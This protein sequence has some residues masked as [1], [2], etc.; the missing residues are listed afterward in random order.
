MVARRMAP[1]GGTFL[2]PLD[3][4]VVAGVLALLI[5]P[6]VVSTTAA[7]LPLR[8][9]DRAADELVL[10]TE[11]G[12]DLQPVP[13]FRPGSDAAPLASGSGLT[14]GAALRAGVRQRL[15]AVLGAAHAMAV[16][17][18]IENPNVR[19]AEEATRFGNEAQISYP[20]R[21]PVVEDVLGARGELSPARLATLN[22]AAALLIL[23]A[24]YHGDALPN[25][26]PV[27]Y[28][29]L[30]RGRAGGCAPQLN[31]AFLV[32]TDVHPRDDDSAQEFMQ[33]AAACPGDPTPLWL[34]GQFQS[35][36][37]DV[38]AQIDAGGVPLSERRA[39]PFETFRRLQSEL[40]GSHAGWSG[41]AD[42]HLRLAYQS[43]SGAP[44]TARNHFRQ[45]RVLY[46]HA[47]ALTDDP[48]L[49][50][51]LARA[52]AGLGEY[53]A[54]VAEQR[55]AVAGQDHAAHQVRLVEYLERAGRFAA[56][57]D[58]G[59]RFLQAA[60]DLAPRRG[61]YPKG[62]REV[63]PP[64]P[65]EDEDANLPVSWG[66]GVVR[67]VNLVLTPDFGGAGA[68][69]VDLAFIPNFRPERG[70]TGYD[71]WCRAWSH[72]R[73]LVLAGRHAEALA[74]LPDT[75]SA[76]GPTFAGDACRTFDGRAPNLVAIAAYEAGDTPAAVEW[77]RSDPALDLSV[78]EEANPE[79][80]R[81]H[82]LRQ[83]LWRFGGNLERAEA[84]A[85]EWLAAAP[86]SP[87]ALDRRGEIAFLLG[88]YDEAAQYFAQAEP[89]DE[90]A[91]AEAQLKQG[92]ALILASRHDEARP[93]LDAAILAAAPL[94]V[95]SDEVL[96][97]DPAA[98]ARYVRAAFVTY[99]ARA[100]MGDLELRVGSD[101]PAAAAYGAA[102]TLVADVLELFPDALTML[103][104][105]PEVI[106]N[107]LALAHISA[108][109]AGAAL[110]HAE[111]A[112][113]VDP[114]NPLFLQTRAFAHQE[115]GDLEAAAR[116]YQR[117]LEADPTVFSA[118]NDLGAVR[119]VQ[120]RTAEAVAAFRQAVGAE[121][122]YALG[123]FNLGVAL[124]RLGPAEMVRS[125]AALSQAV[126]LDRGLRDREREIVFDSEPYFTTLDLSRPLPPRWTFV[127]SYER[128]P[129]GVAAGV[130]VL[131]VLRL[132]LVLLPEQGSG[133]VVHRVLE[134][135]RRR[136]AGGWSW[137]NS[138]M[139][140]WIA[141]TASVVVLVW[142]ALLSRAMSLSERVL[143]AVAALLLVGV[144][145]R[146]RVVWSRMH[147]VEIEH[148]T[149]PA[150]LALAAITASVGVGW[151]PMPV[152]EPQRSVRRFH[153]VGPIAVGAVAI[154]LLLAGRLTE[155]PLS[156]G[157]GAG[158]LTVSAS[159]LLP[160][161]PYDGASM[162]P[163]TAIVL[164]ILLLAVAVLLFFR[165][166]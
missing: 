45:A 37:A 111:R 166:L 89:A 56:A 57:A 58:D 11:P 39:R 96:V 51:G 94:A 25:A 82:D 158:G 6:V 13:V 154:L 74:A 79:L 142:P 32:A 98:G 145:V 66:T 137:L 136:Q 83:N 156:R 38:D 144:Y 124:S 71:R 68:A 120:G 44:F 75:F 53:G 76:D 121:N 21:Y 48:G 10:R 135:Q 16:L 87:T 46:E 61:L 93:V 102:L 118:A 43:F 2:R 12:G 116:D 5:F 126:R 29:L 97:G 36:R 109:E 161:H 107:N 101:D 152:A 160:V 114:A 24:A 133:A 62:L 59:G 117:A 127:S 148:R 143:L 95:A 14:D 9:A 119:L 84:I 128:A 20:F 162:T 63:V 85:E 40:P 35:H 149:W 28:A 105:R 64:D 27:A 54:A 17:D 77:L 151:T 110:P 49:H 3:I 8:P 70:V 92:A 78:Y 22:D 67:G 90:L 88:R 47:L 7:S 150:A 138:R 4:L 163:R 157:M 113:A 153:V 72:R 33:A 140:A 146:A 34:L 69:L 130:L 91:R 108:G 81:L 60:P 100:Q 26:A 30:D 129:V 80:A 42:A 18:L 104:W 73:D 125:Q 99:Y 52:L 141:V 147:R 155:V 115:G 1:A 131:V 122:A 31:L 123:W 132:L 159:L 139:T 164:D 65:V 55:V 19:V 15:R 86:D 41:A 103:P 23:G 106:R 50:G 112:V 134:R 165:V